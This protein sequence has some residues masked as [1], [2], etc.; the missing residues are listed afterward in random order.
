MPDSFSLLIVFILSAL[1][2]ASATG[3]WIGFARARQIHDMPG[4]RRLHLNTTPRGGGVGIALAV[5]V[6]LA[7][8][9]GHGAEPRTW[10]GLAAGIGLFAAVGLFDDLRPLPVLAKLILQLLAAVLLVAFLPAMASGPDLWLLALA[11]LAAA[12]VV[13]VWNFMD[14]SNGLVAMQALL[15]ALALALWPGQDGAVRVAAL[16][17]AGACAGFLPF[18]IPN[19]RVFLGDVGSHVLGAAV[20]GLFIVSWR[21]GTFGIAQ[22][23]LIGSALLLDSL[24]TLSRRAIAGRPVWRAHREHLYQYAV[25]RGHSHLRVCLS[26]AA[27]TT[28]AIAVAALMRESRQSAIWIALALVLAAGM[29]LH[30]RFRRHWL[31]RSPHKEFEQ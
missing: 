26:Y 6:V 29:L 15:M 19:A 31:Q 5:L 14:G 13:N 12:F 24:L 9:A 22:V 20:F 30:Y 3:L 7:W 21:N 4:Q 28:M 17:L 2:C 27:W 18:N 11:V 10:L 1:L 8:I 23:L 16:A 25:R